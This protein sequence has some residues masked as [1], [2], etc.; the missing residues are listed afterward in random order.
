MYHLCD[1]PVQD[2]KAGD[3]YIVKAPSMAISK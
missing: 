2:P 1:L 3:V